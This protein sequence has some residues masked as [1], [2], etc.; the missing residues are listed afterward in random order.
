MTATCPN[1]HVSTTDDYCDQCG[2]PISAAPTP[3]ASDVSVAPSGEGGAEP[4]SEAPA[5]PPGEP[6]PQCGAARHGDDR[7][8]EACGY[9]FESPPP[10]TAPWEAVASADRAQFDHLASDG[11]SFPDSYVE[12]RF[13][14]TADY[15]RIGRNHGQTPADAVEI[16]LAGAPED[17][18]IS[19]V[20]A[21]LERQSDG[22]Y[23]LR[24]L[25]S[26][27]GT[28][29]NDDP[30]PVSA[31]ASAAVPLADGDRIHIGAW[32][33]ITLRHT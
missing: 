10:G 28:T 17:P 20:H 14:L 8:C 6:C 7:Y 30:T 16:N 19:H 2:V 12:R 24:D 9:D 32:T 3:A 11:V 33:T 13:P 15:V 21:V 22:S 25:G 4:S 27:N 18:A 26:T 31:D 1:G 29:V 23:T 5:A